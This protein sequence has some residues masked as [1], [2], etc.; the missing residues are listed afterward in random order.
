MLSVLLV[1]IPSSI[2]FVL[3]LLLFLA[4]LIL[5]LILNP[6]VIFPLCLT[7]DVGSRDRVHFV[8]IGVDVAIYAIH[9]VVQLL[10]FISRHVL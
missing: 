10:L 2:P 5:L 9:K 4:S 6:F 7:A 3:L 1:S 8:V